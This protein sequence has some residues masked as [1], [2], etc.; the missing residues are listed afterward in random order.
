[1]AVCNDYQ[2]QSIGR[3]L[4][5]ETEI[6]LQQKGFNNIELNARKVALGFYETLGYVTEGDYFLENGIEHIKMMKRL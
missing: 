5:N 3:K 6:T 4:I 2:G 1:M